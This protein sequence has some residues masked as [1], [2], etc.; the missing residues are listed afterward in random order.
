MSNAKY[1]KVLCLVL[2]AFIFV[3]CSGFATASSAAGCGLSK[4]QISTGTE[5]SK[6]QQVIVT[7]TPSCW[8]GSVGVNRGNV[9]TNLIT[10]SVKNGQGTGLVTKIDTTQEVHPYASNPGLR[11]NNIIIPC[12][13][14]GSG[15]TKLTISSSGSSKTEKITITATPSTWAGSVEM[16]SLTGAVLATVNV[17]SSPGHV[18]ITAGAEDSETVHAVYL[19]II[20]NSITLP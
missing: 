12:S 19:G 10:V 16:V 7:A 8:S 9:D 14:S 18:T 20:S 13:C 15:L 6:A 11:G 4:I 3:G 5:T 2:I 1:M 17:P